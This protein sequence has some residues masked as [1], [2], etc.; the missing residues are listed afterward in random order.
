M[1]FV[2]LDLV[3]PALEKLPHWQQISL[4]VVFSACLLFL[5]MLVIGLPLLS[6]KKGK[7]LEFSQTGDN[8]FLFLFLFFL[9]G[10]ITLFIGFSVGNAA[11]FWK[12]ILTCI[13]FIAFLACTCISLPIV[14]RFLLRSTNW[15]SLKEWLWFIG[16]IG[17]TLL[18]LRAFVSLL[19]SSS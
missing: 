15:K 17:I 3:Q 1:F 14:L 13:A 7:L 11:G 4:T 10:W 12:G 16:S 2:P 18:L 8:I 5:F 6:K 19:E 9:F